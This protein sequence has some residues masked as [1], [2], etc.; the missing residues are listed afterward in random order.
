MSLPLYWLA[1]FGVIACW[2]ACFFINDTTSVSLL[3]LCPAGA[4]GW[5]MILRANRLR[6]RRVFQALAAIAVLAYAAG[7][8]TTIA[9]IKGWL[10]SDEE[11]GA[12]LPWL[13]GSVFYL[14]I[15]GIFALVS[16]DPR[17]ARQG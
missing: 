7:A 15:A 1:M 3:M 17:R 11:M 13:A 10:P 12:I 8:L 2:I 6:F 5:F 4:G 9:N 14:V 16:D